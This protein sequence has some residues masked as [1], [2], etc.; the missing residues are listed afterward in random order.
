[1]L[2]VV[3]FGGAVGSNRSGVAI[4][5]RTVYEVGQLYYQIET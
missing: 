1:M 2:H 3:A 4:C 5:K